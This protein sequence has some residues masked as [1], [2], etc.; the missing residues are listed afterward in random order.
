MRWLRR[1]LLAV[2]GLA[3]LLGLAA[4][5]LLAMAW[6]ALGSP[7]QGQRLQEVAGSP[8]YSAQRGQFVN[9]EQEKVDAVRAR[10]EESGS[11][12]ERVWRVLTSERT[13]GSPP[14]PL[15]QERPDFSA[16]LQGGGLK[17]VWFGHSSFLLQIGGKLVLVDPVFGNAGPL[18]FVVPRFQDAVVRPQDLPPVDYVLLSHDHYDHLEMETVRFYA[19]RGV[20]FVAPL[21]VGSH[22][23][24]W[25]VPPERVL[26]AD[27][28]QQLRLDGIE[29]V[30]TPSQHF[31]G[32][33]GFST[34]DTLW[35][36][37][38]IRAGGHSVYFSGDSGYGGHFREIG[39]RHGPFDVAFLEN[40]QYNQQWREVHLMPHEGVRAFRELRARR[41][42]PVHWGMFDL[43]PH[44]WYD[45]IEAIADLGERHGIDMVA[46]RIGQVLDLTAPRR[47]GL[48]ERWWRRVMGLLGGGGGGGEGREGREG[49]GQPAK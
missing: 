21:G 9:E 32:R 36:S 15:P 46:P 30:A 44:N 18:W 23:V 39:R 42:F 34:N 37:W 20:T 26:E 7:P 41:Y 4:G 17:V 12:A 28:W 6:P 49:Q 24:G 22:L 40:G 3:L 48:L 33:A 47:E 45:P 19:G 38:V 29:F 1:V 14:G 10:M 35:A 2:A 8:N 27:W 13:Q 16:L 31:S 5:V 11:F 25:G 43:A